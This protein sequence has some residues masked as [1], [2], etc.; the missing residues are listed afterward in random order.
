MRSPL[1]LVTGSTDGI[2]RQ[3]ALDLARSGAT[4]I[5]HGRTLATLEAAR[6]RLGEQA[7]GSTLHVVAGDLATL[8]GV[9]ALADA[10]LAQFPRLDVLLHNAGVYENDPALTVDGFERTIA[11][12]HLA[13]FLLTH[14]LRP[15]LDRGSRVVTVASVAHQR[16]RIDVA[17]FRSLEGYDSYRAYAQSKLANVL[18]SSALAGRLAGA[19]VTSN[20]LHP[21]VVGTKLLVQGFGMTGTETL[22]EG[23]KTSVHLALSPEVEHISGRYFVRSREVMPGGVGADDALAERLFEESAKLV[24]VLPI[25][26]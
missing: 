13:P 25:T 18:F 6:Q 21:G 1:I 19:G 10:V 23:A 14:R 24:G 12:N 9:H 26:D 11:I 17:S 3:T 20:C 5:L 22:E 7:P 4:I 16:G 15:A 8:A 2:G